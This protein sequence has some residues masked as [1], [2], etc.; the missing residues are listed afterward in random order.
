V[1]AEAARHV[2]VVGAKVGLERVHRARADDGGGDRAVADHLAQS[3]QPLPVDAGAERFARDAR[4]SSAERSTS[5]SLRAER[6]LGGSA[7]LGAARSLL[8]SRGD[9]V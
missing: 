3:L 9:G 8:K 5:A 4:S 7:L 6:R 2:D 1:I